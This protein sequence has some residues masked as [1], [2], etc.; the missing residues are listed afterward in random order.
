MINNKKHASWQSILIVLIMSSIKLALLSLKKNLNHK[1]STHLEQLL[2]ARE[3]YWT[4]QLFTLQPH[5]VN[6]RREL[7]SKNRIC[8]NKS[9]ITL[10]SFYL[11]TLAMF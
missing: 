2:L 3:A 6:K 5:G 1:S 11:S 7:K 10:I 4:S 8:Y 9:L